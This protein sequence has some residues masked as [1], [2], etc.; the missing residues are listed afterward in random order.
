MKNWS[1]TILCTLTLFACIL[2]GT[3][4]D[5]TFFSGSATGSWG[6]VTKDPSDVASIRNRDDRNNGVAKFNWGRRSDYSDNQFTFN[7]VGSYWKDAGWEA[8][9]DDAFLLGNFW[10]RNERTYNSGGVDGVDLDIAIALSDPESIGFTFSNSFSINNTPDYTGNDWLDRDFVN[11]TNTTG[12]SFT[13][14]GT[15]YVL[16]ILGFSTNGGTSFFTEFQNPEHNTMNAGL[17]GKISKAGG[18]QVP[19]PA[20]VFLLGSGLLGLFGFRKKFRKPVN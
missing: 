3:N 16:N 1:K 12:N 20:T 19:E 5:A 7:G 9:E 15:E 4:A 10:Y 11:L 18:G 14:N 2:I 13:Y 17:Y 8:D 6:N